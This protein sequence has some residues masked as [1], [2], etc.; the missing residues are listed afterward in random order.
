VVAAGRLFLTGAEGEDRIVLAI[1]PATGKELWRKSYRRERTETSNGMNGPASP[2]PAT[3]GGA[4]FAFF[5]EIGLIALEAGGEER[6]RKALARSAA[7][8]GSPARR[9]SPRAGFCS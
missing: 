2:T 6:W 4:V 3:G 1:D 9:C 8:T 5:P 7:C